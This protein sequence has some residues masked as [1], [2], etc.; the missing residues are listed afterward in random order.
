VARLVAS[1]DD[2]ARVFSVVSEE[3]GRLLAAQTS[4]MIRFEDGERATVV[5]GWSSGQAPAVEVGGTVPLDGPTAASRVYRTGRPARVESYDG[6]PG[7][8][9]AR[10]RRLGFRSAVAAP[11]MLAGR[12]WG[13]VI[14]SS[15]EP[16]PFPAG[17]EQRIGEFAKLTAQAL[18]N[19]DA[20][21]QLAAS[22]A[23]LVKAADE[24]RR[25][26]ERNLHDGAQQRLVALALTVR[27]AQR[28]LETDPEATAALL[29][30]SSAELDQAMAELRELARGLHPAILSDLG[31]G[32][33]L[34]ELADRAPVPVELTTSIEDRLPDPVEAAA[35]YVVAEALTNIAKYARACCAQ[36]RL[37]SDASRLIVTVVDDGG[38]GADPAAGS[39][40]RGLADRVEAL[41]GRLEVHSPAGGGTT[42]RALIPFG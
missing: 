36:V 24:E 11:I 14:V 23:R 30:R 7:E 41:D 37:E 22:R 20:R 3:V 31:L 42:I 16:E 4:N 9:A 38:G 33:A 8:L 10:L 39:G 19:A 40:L 29:A 1:E 13:C 21:E 26:L 25:R 5:G 2:P 12:L 35:Y 18:A 27:L 28:K 15:V 34:T 6:M 32:P 17:A